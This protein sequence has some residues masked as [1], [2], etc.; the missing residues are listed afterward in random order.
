[1]VVVLSGYSHTSTALSVS[2]HPMVM[3]YQ[4]MGQLLSAMMPAYFIGLNTEG[5]MSWNCREA[6]CSAQALLAQKLHR[7]GTQIDTEVQL[8]KL[9]ASPPAT[10]GF[11]PSRE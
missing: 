6:G 10:T 4:P 5:G 1:M 8:G 7:A 3:T 9:T 11:P 2:D